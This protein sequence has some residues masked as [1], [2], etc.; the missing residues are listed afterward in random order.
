MVAVPMDLAVRSQ[1]VVIAQQ[2]HARRAE[3]MREPQRLVPG[4]LTRVD[5]I[6]RRR[7][8]RAVEPI[9]PLQVPDLARG[10]ADCPQLAAKARGDAV[11][12]LGPPDVVA[13]VQRVS[14][15]RA[16][17]RRVD[18]YDSAG[19]SGFELDGSPAADG[20]AV[21]FREARSARKDRDVIALPAAGARPEPAVAPAFPAG[22]SGFGGGTSARDGASGIARSFE[23]PGPAQSSTSPFALSCAQ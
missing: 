21:L 23:G 17:V 16:L 19:W 12:V 8:S 20:F 15:R 9:Y 3:Q 5:V 14:P 2:H 6:A 11:E 10:F 4:I 1:A 13:R 22:F 18:R 7:E